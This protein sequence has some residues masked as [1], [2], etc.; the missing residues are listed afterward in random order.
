MKKN[1]T[2]DD[3]ING[4]EGAYIG[5]AGEFVGT[6]KNADKKETPDGFTRLRLI[7]GE[8]ELVFDYGNNIWIL[9]R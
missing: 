2:R 8:E 9:K 5:F 1:I 4:A 7:E 3:L 6:G